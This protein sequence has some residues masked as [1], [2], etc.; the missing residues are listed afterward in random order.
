[1]SERPRNAGA[2]R[3]IRVGPSPRHGTGVFARARIRTGARIGAFEGRPTRRDGPHVLW[4]VDDDGSAEGLLVENELRYL[5]HSRRPNA[6][7]DGTD[8]YALRNIQPG[9]EILIHY[10]ADWNDVD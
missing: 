5:N 6:E 2:W 1:M 10:G 3:R 9:A 8:L 4:L 7:I